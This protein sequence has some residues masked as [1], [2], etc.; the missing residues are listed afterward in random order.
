MYTPPR[1]ISLVSRSESAYSTTPSLTFIAT[2][3]DRQ[4]RLTSRPQ[5]TPQYPTHSPSPAQAAHRHLHH[6]S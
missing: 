5:T 4:V 3:L 2:A 1:P 6:F